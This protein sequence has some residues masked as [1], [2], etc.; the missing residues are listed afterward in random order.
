MNVNVNT[1]NSPTIKKNHTTKQSNEKVEFKKFLDNNQLNSKNFISANIYRSYT[2]NQNSNG[3][4]TKNPDK[5]INENQSDNAEKIT[6]KSLNEFVDTDKSTKE[7]FQI[8]Q[9]L[10]SLK[11]IIESVD[12]TTVTN[13]VDPP[14]ILDVLQKLT[15]QVNEVKGYFSL[16][17]VVNKKN[18][19]EQLVGNDKS[20]E[21]VAQIQQVL[22]SLSFMLESVE[23][24]TTTNNGKNEINSISLEQLV[25]VEK[26][27]PETKTLL[28]NNL[29]EIVDLIE[30]SKGNNVVPPKIL[31]VLKKLTTQVNEVKGDFSLLKVVNEKPIVEDKPSVDLN[32]SLDNNKLRSKVINFVELDVDSL[33]QNTDKPSEQLVGNDKS[34]EKVA[35][36]QQVLQSLSFMLESV[37]RATTTNNGKNG[38]NSISLEQLVGVEK[39]APETQTLLKNNLNEIVDLIEKSKGNNVV[40]P[41]ILDVLKKLTTQVN[42]VKGDFSLLKVVNEK[43]IV[44]DKPSV[45]LNKSLDN[46]KLRSKVINFVEVAVD[47][48]KQNTEKPSEQLVGNDKSTEKVAQIQQVLQSLSFM[49]ESVERA[50]TTNNGK[51]E[52]DSINLEQLV[53]VE[54]LQPETKTLLKNNLN[55]IVDLIEKSKGNNVDPPKILDVLKKL[56]TQVNEVKGDFSLLKVVNEKPIVEDKPSVDL[57]KSLDNNKLRSKVINFVELAVDSLK[58]NTDKPSEQLVGNDKSTEKVAQIQQVLQSL[59]FM[60]E[61]VERATTTNNGKNELDSI[62]LEQ[63]VGVEK[64]QPETKTL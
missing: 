24:A 39:L 59:S 19:S 62:N 22:Q 26:L 16:L 44:E 32:K 11:S 48:L 27:A 54:K 21:K 2:E 64:L 1:I 43:P 3:T 52:L 35:Q 23:R 4:N 58:Q 5:S 55:E 17:K 53:G 60:L 50:T 15:T 20:T 63:L 49:L 7:M 30:K 12:D 56:T 10:Q 18:T 40:P 25:G 57:N 31:D 38:I 36:I 46:N 61:S 29:N 42:E 37:E 47:S 14:K 6:D 9:L 33:K 45:D 13:N 28:K 41:K 8:E 51:N 34:T